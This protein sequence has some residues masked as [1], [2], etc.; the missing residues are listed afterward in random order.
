MTINVV[1]SCPDWLPQTQTWIY[2]QVR[3]LPIGRVQSHVVC[4]RTENLNQFAVPNLH[5]LGGRRSC[6]FWWDRV[7]RKLRLWN[8]STFLVN[9]ARR[10]GAK[11][12]HSH[13]GPAGWSDIASVRRIPARHIVTFYG[14]DMSRLPVI[15]PIWRERYKELFATVDCVLCEGPFMRSALIHLGCPRGKVIIHHLGIE[16]DKIT[17][18]P[19]RWTPGAP[20]RV[21]IA[22]TFTEKKGIPDALEALGRIKKE[23]NIEITVVG[24]AHPNVLNELRELG[25]IRR[26]TD[27]HGLSS[28][29]RFLGYQSHD[30]LFEVAYDHHIFLSPSVTAT[31]GDSEGGAPVTL[32]EMAATGMPVVSTY[33]CDIPNVIESGRSGLLATEHDVDHLAEHIRWLIQNPDAWR[34]M[35]TTAR[36]RIDSDFNVRTQGSR[37]ASIYEDLASRNPC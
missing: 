3:N 8:H 29:V 36:Q 10:A 26:T 14:Y 7:P 33:H 17:F 9:T 18:V 34:E 24:D 25:H 4:Q 27:A 21:L 13:F 15:E 23:T 5:V 16:T 30:R 12:V 20:L 2:S 6:R 35:V 32:I 19:R 1:Q 22:A 37:L 31:D 28:N 11:L